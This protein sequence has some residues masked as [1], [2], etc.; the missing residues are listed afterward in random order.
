MSKINEQEYGRNLTT[1]LTDPDDNITSFEY[2]AA[3]REIKRS[4]GNG[5]EIVNEYNADGQVITKTNQKGSD[6]ISS[7]Q[8]LYNA[9]HRANTSQQKVKEIKS[10]CCNGFSQKCGF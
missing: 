4:L 5:N 3:G 10:S 2:D 8:Y 6:I 9:S 7:F 1:S